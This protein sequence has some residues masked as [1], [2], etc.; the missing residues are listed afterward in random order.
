VM[1][2]A[3]LDPDQANAEDEA[4]ADRL[5]QELHGPARGAA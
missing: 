2:Y 1:G 3:A 5:E 4:A